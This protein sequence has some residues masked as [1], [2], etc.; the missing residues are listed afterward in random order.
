[1][2]VTGNALIKG[3]SG[4]SQ[5]TLSGR[6]TLI[7]LGQDN[8]TIGA[9]G[10]VSVSAG[11]DT[12]VTETAAALTYTVATGAYAAS[13]SVS[14]GEAVVAGGT[15]GAVTLTTQAKTA[16]NVA[17]ISGVAAV[18]LAGADTVHASKGMDS[19]AIFGANAQ[20]Y[21]GSANLVL[22]NNDSHA[23]D[24]VTV[25]GGA[26]SLTYNQGATALRFMGSSGTASINGGSGSLSIT[27][28][29]GHLSVIGGNAGLTF[30]AGTGV[31]TLTLTPGGADV[32]FGAGA[33]F[34]QEASYGSADLY[35]L[36][37]GSGGGSDTIAGFRAGT[38]KLLLQGVAVAK[39]SIVQGSISITLTDHT[40]ILLAGVS[41]PAHIFS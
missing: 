4:N 25:Q 13:L 41:N 21:A 30:V 37:A 17:L 12:T 7:G 24:A 32:T 3:S 40:Q 14:G 2:T 28:G 16:V 31:S 33:T 8:V 23:G 6:D 34:V 1:M 26:G 29:S 22:V 19:V 11:A 38:D 39:E 15:A 9:G 20:I 36:I 18:T 27:G 10:V 35:R 5:L